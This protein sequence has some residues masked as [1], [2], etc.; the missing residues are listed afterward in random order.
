MIEINNLFKGTEKIDKAFIKKTVENVLKEEGVFNKNIDLSIAIIDSGEIKKI[1]NQYRKKNKPT[2]VLSFGKIG[3]DLLEIVICPT[4][5]KKNGEVFKEE[6]KRV[7]IHGVLHL[8][9]YD[10]EKS[11]KEALEMFTKQDEYFQLI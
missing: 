11:R 2:D 7:V 9:G 4:E 1:N 5:V 10:H 8:L 3:E 6:L